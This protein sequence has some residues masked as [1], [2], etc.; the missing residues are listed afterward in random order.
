MINAHSDHT[1]I[2]NRHVNALI[3]LYRSQVLTCFSTVVFD[4]LR[5]GHCTSSK[6]RHVWT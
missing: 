2:G 5:V 6:E 1:A 4:A 3:C